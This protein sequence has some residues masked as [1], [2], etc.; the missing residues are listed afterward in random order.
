M[1][2][3]T[4]LLNTAKDLI[5]V[6]TTTTTYDALLHQSY[7]TVL[8]QL[9]L[10]EDW[11]TEKEFLSAVAEQDIYTLST[12]R[13]TRVLAVFHNRLAL[14][15]VTTKN[16]DLLST[17]TSDDADQPE[18]YA[19]NALP[20]G[21]DGLSSITPE[22]LVVI[23]APS[24]DATGEQGL[25]VFRVSTPESTL[26]VPYADDLLVFL[27][28]AHFCAV[29]HDARDLPAAQFWA[30]LAQLFREALQRMVP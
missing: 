6:A 27:T 21:L 8:A 13:F 7:D 17:W 15:R 29:E 10:D 19:L 25:V 26:P 1:T 18:R 14:T 5:R 22:Q 11:F 24:V 28:V 20:P 30:A 23:P 16:L 2:M 3:P 12:T 4:T 9:C